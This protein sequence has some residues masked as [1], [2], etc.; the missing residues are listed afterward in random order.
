ML[1]LS[2]GGS[3]SNVVDSSTPLIAAVGMTQWGMFVRIRL[4]FSECF[5]PYRCLISQG[6]ALPASPEGKLL[7]HALGC[8][9]YRKQFRPFGGGTAHRPFPTVSLVGVLFNQGSSKD[10]LLWLRF[11]EFAYCFW[12]VSGCPAASSVRA[13]PC[14]LPR[15]GSFFLPYSTPLRYSPLVQAPGSKEVGTRY[16]SRIRSTSRAF[17]VVKFSRMAHRPSLARSFWRSSQ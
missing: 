12:S 1:G 7:Y 10:V 15:R 17:S 13:A 5:T 4:L 16:S 14:Q 3:L 8:W 6:C 11:Y 2:C 9:A